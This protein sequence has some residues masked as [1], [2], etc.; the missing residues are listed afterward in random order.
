MLIHPSIMSPRSNSPSGSAKVPAGH[1]S[2]ILVGWRDEE[3]DRWHHCLIPCG[4]DHFPLGPLWIIFQYTF[5]VLANSDLKTQ[6]HKSL[7]MDKSTTHYYLEPDPKAMKSSR[8]KLFLRSAITWVPDSDKKITCK[9]TSCGH[10]IHPGSKCFWNA[11]YMSN[12]SVNEA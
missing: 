9:T 2:G 12:N 5:I 11:C 7:L 10:Q 3:A 6:I 8:K 1:I 4:A